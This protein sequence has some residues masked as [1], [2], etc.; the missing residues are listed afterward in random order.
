MPTVIETFSGATV[1]AW[2][3]VITV[4]FF[5]EFRRLVIQVAETGGANPIDF[6][7]LASMNADMSAYEILEDALGNAAFDVAA[8]TNEYE[9]L[10]DCWPYIAVQL[11]N[12]GGGANIG[13]Y[14]VTISGG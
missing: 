12:D 8:G 13:A 11:R 3:T 5:Q 6:R 9:T 14:T 1:A 2:T 7:V 10:C 4:T